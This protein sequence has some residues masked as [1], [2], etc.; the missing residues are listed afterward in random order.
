MKTK[1]SERPNILLIIADQWRADCLG[2]AG[3]PVVKTPHL[4]ALA[5]EG[6]YFSHAYCAV[7]SCVAARA[8]L[9]TGLHQKNHGFV[10]Y[11]DFRAWNYDCPLPQVFS[12]QGYHTQAVGKMH[13]YPTRKLLGFHNVVLHDGYL[14]R[15]RRKGM[16][17][18]YLDD[19]SHWL[20][21]QHRSFEVDY[22][23]SGLDCNGYAVQLWPYSERQHPSAWVAQ[24]SIRFLQ[25][26]DPEKPFFLFSSFHRPHPPLDPPQ[27]CYL[28]YQD[29]P[30]PQS[31]VGD[32]VDFPQQTRAVPE[33][34]V[35]TRADEIADA[36]RAYYAQMTFIDAQINRLMLALREQDAYDNTIVCFIADHG[37]MLYDHHL[38]AK[39][40][41]FEGSVKI[42]WI[43]WLSPKLRQ[44]YGIR[45]QQQ[46]EQIVELRDVFASL[47]DFAELPISPGLD[48]K[49]ILPLLQ[50]QSPQWRNYLH[51]EHIDFH[52]HQNNRNWGNHW[53]CDG[54]HKYCW[55]SA[56]GRELLFDLARDPQE[57]CD[58]S[59]R[60]P[61]DLALWRQRLA[62]ELTGR[63]EG[64]VANG[65]LVAGRKGK[66][67]LENS[68]NL[69]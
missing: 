64:Y 14:H 54:K 30:I 22:T 16:D 44:K 53:L 42:P 52:D 58:L 32:W 45:S 24:E 13:V 51:G 38:I 3:H 65:R 40:V 55:F 48:G 43:V 26:R 39:T 56:D 36:K 46:I 34:P 27:S 2:I 35:P 25:R 41:P 29:A 23:A 47:C 37:E 21:S 60:K 12:E 62:S 20:K 10:G 11:N 59:A 69:P 33:A 31:P 15:D 63:P 1:D 66:A 7:P 57:C 61:E 68:R 19:Y 6:A 17:Y 4:D 8:A 28:R 9:L 18:D 49:S 50:G 5:Q 67:V